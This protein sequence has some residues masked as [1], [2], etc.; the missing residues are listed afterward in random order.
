MVHAQVQATALG[1][2]GDQ[3]ADGAGRHDAAVGAVSADDRQR[4]P[5]GPDAQRPVDRPGD[6]RADEANT[7]P[8]TAEMDVP[9]TVDRRNVGVHGQAAGPARSR[10][11]DRRRRRFVVRHQ[12]PVV[13]VVVVFGVV[14]VVVVVQGRRRPFVR[15]LAEETVVVRWRQARG[16]QEQTRQKE[17][18]KMRRQLFLQLFRLLFGRVF[19]L[20]TL[21]GRQLSPNFFHATARFR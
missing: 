5:V 20:K 2:D 11:R 1:A 6:G 15:R 17:Q 16:G 18:K 3:P 19:R 4:V 12:A 10:V 7:E 8:E 14:D 21:R 13:G 9:A